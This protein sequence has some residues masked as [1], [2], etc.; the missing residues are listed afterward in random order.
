VGVEYS[1]SL[2]CQTS[3]LPLGEPQ[4]VQGVDAGQLNTL[5]P[6]SFPDM[7]DGGPGG[8]TGIERLEVGR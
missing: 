6:A 1:S 2:V 3:E 4:V 8:G 5:L 7:T